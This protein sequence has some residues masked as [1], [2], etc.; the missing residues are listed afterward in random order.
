MVIIHHCDPETMN[1]YATS[2]LTEAMIKTLQHGIYNGSQAR[3]GNP[4]LEVAMHDRSDFH[5][6]SHY[7]LCNILDREGSL[8]HFLVIDAQTPEN[9]AVWYVPDTEECKYGSDPALWDR[10]G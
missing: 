10:G 2:P 4:S 8:D 1:A 5:G 9:D 6:I 7:E 3:F